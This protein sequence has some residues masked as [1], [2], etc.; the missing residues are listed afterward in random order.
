MILAAVIVRTVAGK[1]ACSVVGQLA[2]A[3]G[4][5]RYFHFDLPFNTTFEVRLRCLL[6][7]DFPHDGQGY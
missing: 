7:L 3:K 5:F 1:N 2:V 4:P 6:Y